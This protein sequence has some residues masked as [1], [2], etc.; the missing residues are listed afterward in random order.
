MDNLNKRSKWFIFGGAVLIIFTALVN[1]GIIA[2]DDYAC[3]ISKIIPA[4]N[5][6]FDQVVA[7]RD[8]RSPI[9]PLVLLSVTK[10]AYWFGVEDPAWQLRLL[11]VLIG[12]SS[13][14]SF[15]WVGLSLFKKDKA[16]IEWFLFLSGFYFICP[17]IFT[18]PLIESL[19]APFLTLSCFFSQKYWDKSQRRSLALALVFLVFAS[20]FRFQSGICLTALLG[21]IVLKKNLKDLIF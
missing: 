3:I 19:S 15:C 11:L 20:I 21:L 14:A 5:L 13:Y 16:K 10:V 4:Q 1:I 18:R 9:A 17:L 6:T 2:I 8:I 7:E 12:I